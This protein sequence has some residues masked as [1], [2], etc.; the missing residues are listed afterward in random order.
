MDPEVIQFTA[1]S[2]LSRLEKDLL[3]AVER[4]EEFRPTAWNARS[5]R[6]R[7]GLIRAILL[8]TP[9][10]HHPRSAA[11]GEPVPVSVTSNG[12]RIAGPAGADPPQPASVGPVAGPPTLR[13]TGPL[14]LAGLAGRDGGFLPSLELRHC[15]IE[16]PINLSGTRL[17]AL[18]LEKSCFS[19]LAA[20]DAR[21][22]GGV[23]LSHCGPR[24]ASP[25]AGE[26]EFLARTKAAV[27]G[28]IDKYVW[29]ETT[30]AA[31]ATRRCKCSLCALPPT[32][33]EEAD[34]DGS[35]DFCCDI[36]LEGA[37]IGAQLEIVRTHLRAPRMIG[38]RYE[39]PKIADR[40]A[41]YLDGVKVDGSVVI[42]RC[43]FVGR[44]S[45]RSATVTNDVW[46]HG[47][48]FVASAE[49][50][51]FNFQF[52][53]IGGLLVA[54]AHEATK[55]E[56]RE[57]GVRAFPVVVVGH[58][59]GLS[60]RAGEVWIGEGFYFGHDPLKRG[61]HATINFGKC[62]VSRTFK[63]GTYHPFQDPDRPTGGAWIHGEICLT[64]ANLGKNL[65]IHGVDY[66]GVYDK[67]GLNHGFYRNFGVRCDETPHLRLSGQGLKVDRR[68]F[69]SKGRFH[70]S[71]ALPPGSA[72]SRKRSAI[73]FWKSTIGTGLRIESESSCVGAIRLNSCVISR[74]LII[75]CSAISASPEDRSRRRHQRRIPCMLD[76]SESTIAGHVKIGPPFLRRQSPDGGG[77]LATRSVTDDAEREPLKI[78]GGISLQSSSVQGSVLISH[79]TIDLTRGIGPPPPTAAEEGRSGEAEGVSGGK[80]Q[81][82]IQLR[83]KAATE[84]ARIA[85]DFRGCDCGSDLEIRGM[86][87]KLPEPVGEERPPASRDGP[88]IHMPR[89]VET[90]N[91]PPSETSRAFKLFNTLGKP[92]GLAGFRQI[93]AGFFAIVD[94]SGL[95]CATLLDGFGADWGLVY[96]IQLRLA[97]MKLGEVEPVCHRGPGPS[98]RPERH[99]LR[100][101][102]YQH[103]VQRAS[104]CSETPASRNMARI[105]FP[106]RLVAGWRD[107]FVP[108]TYDVF[109]SAYCKAGENLTADRILIEKKDNQNA[110][111]FWRLWRR[112][113][114]TDWYFPL[115]LIFVTAILTGFL[116]NRS[117]KWIFADVENI[118][119]IYWAFV[120]ATL[121][122]FGWPLVAAGF[123]TLFKQLFHY[124]LSTERALLVFAVS[125]A[126]GW[127]GVH[128]AR[129]GQVSIASVWADPAP[130]GILP[131]N[132]VLVREVQDEPGSPDDAAQLAVAGS[133]RPATASLRDGAKAVFARPSPCDRDVSSLV[134]ALDLFI[135]LIDLDQER[136]C[137]VRPAAPE[138]GH[139]DY[140]WWRF[141][142]ALYELLGWVITSLMILTISGVLRRDLER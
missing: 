132:I 71:D 42:E 139:D 11:A 91:E 64:A 8:G 72:R 12:I 140:F 67:L 70:D 120:I 63:V 115:R 22:N 121:V 88:E 17:Q 90:Q 110:L 9:L 78:Q 81:E 123:Q 59:S 96:R 99:R 50:S 104:E 31:K 97:G 137:T 43:V 106:E 102:A 5:S 62:D 124:G 51:T 141:G 111:Y 20:V 105:Y 136:R 134:Y 108:Q 24:K 122:F 33:R 79:V 127:G 75:R 129:N 117:E 10:K 119:L 19:R 131:N 118:G 41:A 60:M 36:D 47:G 95:R 85:L 92:F 109:S 34:Y 107:D 113:F 125:I 53:S 3:T 14:D 25:D 27:H 69:I 15:L 76:I 49:R 21:F 86:R 58:V 26:R 45:L 39:T 133:G 4:G 83:R 16:Q 128:W 74:E 44:T 7:A 94:L 135:P 56:E 77:L 89:A 48:K 37:Q 6:L 73:D 138:L 101:L 61:G 65:E 28:A 54:R 126:V 13:I 98:S 23:L 38:R 116:M 32:D 29:L 46:I 112:W 82:P 142:K 66:D 87:W 30:A 35:C 114:S 68:A 57:H 100:W 93:H 130:R 40:F 52:A 55:Q 80:D 2:A 1:D 84:D 103:T 18:R